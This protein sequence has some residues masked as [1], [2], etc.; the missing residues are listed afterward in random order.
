[1]ACFPLKVKGFWKNLP[2]RRDKPPACSLGA[3]FSGAWF[4]VI[5]HVTTDVTASV[6]IGNASKYRCVAVELQTAMP[7]KGIES[8]KWSC[9]AATLSHYLGSCSNH[10]VRHCPQLAQSSKPP[11]GKWV[12]RMLVAWWKGL[13]N[14]ISEYLKLLGKRVLGIKGPLTSHGRSAAARSLI[15]S[16]WC[17]IL[18]Q[19]PSQ[20]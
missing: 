3:T 6:V 5:A 8:Q 11:R 10:H 15:L 12:K 17:W 18:N 1:M 2:T 13:L 7:S 4:S 9:H 14:V 16:S 20:E 19:C